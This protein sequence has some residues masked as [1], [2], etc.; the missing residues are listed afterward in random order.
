[1]PQKGSTSNGGLIHPK[2]TTCEE[3]LC[4]LCVEVELCALCVEVEL[5]VFCVEVE[6]CV[7]CVEV[8]LCVLCVEVELCVL[9]V[10]VGVCVLCVEVEL[11]IFCVEV[12]LCVLCVEVELRVLC[13]EVKLCV[14]C[15]EVE[16]RVLCVEV[17]LCV[18]CVESSI[19]HSPLNMPSVMSS[20]DLC[21]SSGLT[22]TMSKSKISR[23]KLV[24]SPALSNCKER[25]QYFNSQVCK[26]T[27]MITKLTQVNH[28]LRWMEEAQNE[29]L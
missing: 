19:S 16:L 23:T 5:C 27:E 22:G 14:L 1:M 4:V 26:Y 3:R 12:K 13:V 9:C 15:V 11:C 17:E 29:V 10:E 21:G 25:M 8:E 2:S 7:L 18:L 6:L 20:T 24:T 28:L